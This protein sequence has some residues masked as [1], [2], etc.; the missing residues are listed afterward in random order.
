MRFDRQKLG[1]NCDLQVVPRTLS[2]ENEVRPAKT[3]VKLRFARCPPQPFR[4]KRGSI[5]K[6][7]GKIAIFML[8]GMEKL[9]VNAS[10]CKSVCV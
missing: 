10:V 3:E 9:Y 1:Q 8:S 7:W 2:H 6:N 4:T 5:A